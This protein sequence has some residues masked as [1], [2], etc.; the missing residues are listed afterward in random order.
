MTGQKTEQPT[1][2][3]LQDARKKGQ[4]PRSKELVGALSTFGILAVFYLAF[5][6]FLEV[7]EDLFQSAFIVSDKSFQNVVTDLV[8]M[9]VNQ[10]VKILL[11]IFLVVVFIIILGSLAQGG[12]VFAPEMVKVK[13]ENLSPKKALKNIFSMKNF[14]E[15]L[16]SVLKATLLSVIIYHL[17]H[18]HLNDLNVLPHCGA[19]CVGDIWGHLTLKI[20]VYAACLYLL[21]A[22]FDT[23]FQHYQHIKSLKMTPEEVKREFKDSEGDQH[24]KGMRTA[25]YREIIS[26]DVAS[27]VDRSS[28]IVTNPTHVAVGLRYEKGETDLPLITV[29]ETDEAALAVRQVARKKGVPILENVALARS[30][31]AK[32]KKKNYIPSELIPEVA[33]VIKWVQ[34]LKDSPGD[35]LYDGDAP[36]D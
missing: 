36:L 3:K 25:L 7:L 6:F 19:E 32:G 23:F 17:L 2:K 12:F 27:D 20:F 10:S 24:I 13:P 26:E 9:T 34:G 29:M 28:V 30:L 18:S 4:V 11:P 35:D 1:P 14:V 22:L 16:K 31:L 15:L 5:P 21:V 8:K 33:T